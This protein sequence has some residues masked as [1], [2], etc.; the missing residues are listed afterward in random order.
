MKNDFIYV[1]ILKWK[2]GE[3][4]ALKKLN[5]E[6]TKRIFPLIEIVDYEES[7]K[8]IKDL[9]SFDYGPIYVDT[10][11]AAEDDRDILLSIVKE[12]IKNNKL[13]F[14][15]CYFDDLYDIILKFPKE[16]NRIIIRIPIPEDIYGPSYDDIFSSIQK[17]KSNN[18]IILDLMLDLASITDRG[19]ANRQ[20]RDLKEVIDNYLFGNSFY[21]SIIICS[22]SFPQDISNVPAGTKESF[23]R[24]DI[25]IFEKILKNVKYA[26]IKDKFIYSD[27][28]VTK[29]TDSEIDFSKLRYGILPK[30]KYT[31]DYEYIVLKGQRNQITREIVK[32]YIDLAKEVYE[33]DYYYGENF[34]FGDLEIKERALLLNKKGPGSNKNWVTISAN[35]HIAVVIEQLS[36]LL[37]I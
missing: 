13:I 4:E 33:S 17:Y 11:I 5:N 10:I 30:I 21:N 31:L 2:Q 34:S 19:T 35:H 6:H 24:Y 18:N 22:T 20:L 9:L 15:V 36:S 28:G 7:E 16:L 29:F 25:K 27:Y 26:N 32:S 14:P 1:P 12:G 37:G 23:D 3:Q 8:V